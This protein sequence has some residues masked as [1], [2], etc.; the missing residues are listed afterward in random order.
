MTD[1]ARFLVNGVEVYDDGTPVAGGYSAQADV[2]RQLA[3]QGYPDMRVTADG[4]W[5]DIGDAPA[6]SYN[7]AHGVVGPVDQQPDAP[8][9]TTEVPSELRASMPL[10]LGLAIAGAVLARMRKR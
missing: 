2:Q 4:R 3:A 1:R 7:E 6:Q 8:F 10:L 5:R 9:V